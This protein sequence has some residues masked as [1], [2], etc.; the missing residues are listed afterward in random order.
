MKK[1][2][3]KNTVNKNQ[4]EKIICHTQI[5]PRFHILQACTVKK[6]LCKACD[7]INPVK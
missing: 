6:K 1:Q 5:N 4:T 2:K 7:N 3:Q